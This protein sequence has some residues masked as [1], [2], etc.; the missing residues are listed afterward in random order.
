MYKITNTPFLSSFGKLVDKGQ[1]T[2]TRS[3]MGTECPE[4]SGF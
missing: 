4:E 3:A 2:V 1:A